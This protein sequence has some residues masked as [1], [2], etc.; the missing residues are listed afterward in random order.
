MD[1]DWLDE[2][3]EA[4]RK[5]CIQN[6]T[7]LKSKEEF[8]EYAIN[9]QKQE[10]SEALP[11]P[12]LFAFARRKISKAGNLVKDFLNPVLDDGHE[13]KDE[14][15][16]PKPSEEV[17]AVKKEK[18]VETSMEE[19]KEPSKEKV[20]APKLMKKENKNLDDGGKVTAKKK[21]EDNPFTNEVQ[22]VETKEEL[23]I[24]TKADLFKEWIK[25]EK[26]TKKVVA[27]KEAK[28][29]YES[30]VKYLTAK[31]VDVKDKQFAYSYGGG[32]FGKALK[33]YYP[34]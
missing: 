32:V 22:V 17:K 2:R 3:Y 1:D 29:L 28:V 13:V 23:V 34:E 31:E 14:E 20:E 18:A 24:P 25:A 33:N 9:M 7:E 4:Y 30:Y 5:L 8:K 21:E 12:D 19:V 11:L 16:Q 15:V 26:V 10:D 27:T 6:G